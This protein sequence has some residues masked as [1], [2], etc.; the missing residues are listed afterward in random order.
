MVQVNTVAGA[1]VSLFDE[2]AIG[3]AASGST[4][5][6]TIRLAVGLIISLIAALV[7]LGGMK[8]IGAVTGLFLR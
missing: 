5:E 4:A 3:K 8:R 1:F 6:M 7:L 2:F